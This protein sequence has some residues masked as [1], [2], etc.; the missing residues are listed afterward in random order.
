[1][2]ALAQ[3]EVLVVGRARDLMGWSNICVTGFRVLV[4][5][6][7]GIFVYL[8]EFCCSSFEF[9]CAKSFSFPED[10]NVQLQC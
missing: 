9:T 2:Y 5:V 1:M 10:V 7:G 4:L 3:S 6:S 8:F